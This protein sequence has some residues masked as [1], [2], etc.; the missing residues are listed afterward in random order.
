MI[1][2]K[3]SIF[4]TAMSKRRYF[5]TSIS[6]TSIY[7]TSICQNIDKKEQSLQLVPIKIY[8]LLKYNV[9]FFFV[10]AMSE[11]AFSKG[12]PWLKIRLSRVM[13]LHLLELIVST[14]ASSPESFSIVIRCVQTGARPPFFRSPCP[15]GV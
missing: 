4:K 1:I 3:T 6:I 14:G 13:I 15:L 11:R 2:H 7:I 9:C 12:L 8:I 10:L 5:L